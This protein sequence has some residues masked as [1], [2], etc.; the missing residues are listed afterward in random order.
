MGNV[1]F[2]NT[3]FWMIIGLWWKQDYLCKIE[4]VKITP[5]L[6]FSIWN[7]SYISYVS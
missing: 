4:F 7:I 6:Q 1:L 3:L 5:N 2:V